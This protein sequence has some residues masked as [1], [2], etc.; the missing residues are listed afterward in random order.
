MQPT[1]SVFVDVGASVLLRG[2]VAATPA[3]SRAPRIWIAFT[4]WSLPHVSMIGLREFVSD[5]ALPLYLHHFRRPARPRTQKANCVRANSASS[6]P[7]LALLSTSP[8][9]LPPPDSCASHVPILLHNFMH[10]SN[11]PCYC[12]CAGGSMAV[13]SVPCCG[14]ARRSPLMPRAP[15]RSAQ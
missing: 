14:R 3:K 8:S 6:P 4:W 5:G 2:V 10:T 12:S 13:R 15:Q 7:S 1:V 9:G 11:H